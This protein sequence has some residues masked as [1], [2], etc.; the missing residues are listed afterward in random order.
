[1]KA[2]HECFRQR[3][4]IFFE[5]VDDA[6]GFGRVAG[7]GF[8]AERRDAG[9]GAFDA[10]LGVHAVGQ[11]IVDRVDVA[12][13]EQFRRSCRRRAGYAML[14]SP[15]LGAL[16][17]SGWRRAATSPL[18]EAW[19][20]GMTRRPILAVLRMPQRILS[21]MFCLLSPLRT[22]DLIGRPYSFLAGDSPSRTRQYVVAG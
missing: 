17:A 20:A 16:Q 6:L 7:E 2:V 15:G 10:P 11:R 22:G 18:R 8:L 5:G 19:I 9:L 14:G 3:D 1:M 4:L 21:V 13:G 12:I